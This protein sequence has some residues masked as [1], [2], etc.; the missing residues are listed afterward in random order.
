MQ[1][2]TEIRRS[3]LEQLIQRYGSV[4]ELN[5][6]LGWPR[7]DP[8]LAQIRNANTRAGRAKPYQMGDAMARDIEEKLQLE[9]GWMDTPSSYKELYGDSDQRAKVIELMEAMPPHRWA[10]VVRLVDAI[11]KPSDEENGKD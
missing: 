10:T 8:K 5:A 11:A 7:T 9:H 3:R 2:S 1:T 6:A 4:A